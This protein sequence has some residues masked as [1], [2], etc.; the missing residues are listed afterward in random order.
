MVSVRGGE[1]EALLKLHVAKNVESWQTRFTVLY[2]LNLSPSQST[3]CIGVQS[4]TLVV[5][6]APFLSQS[7]V[8][9]RV[10]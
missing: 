1:G 10:I 4:T 3:Y 2:E 7:H 5:A 9:I 6:R 8:V